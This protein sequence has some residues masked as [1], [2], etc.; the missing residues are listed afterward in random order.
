ME[1]L[2]AARRKPTM[3]TISSTHN[4]HRNNRAGLYS[5]K[6]VIGY[7]LSAAF[8]DNCQADC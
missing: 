6:Y 7:G 2:T 5:G 1:G 4:Q 3:R 8:S